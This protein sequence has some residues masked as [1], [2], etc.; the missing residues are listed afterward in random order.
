M[1]DILGLFNFNHGH[2]RLMASVSNLAAVEAE[3]EN[4]D[5]GEFDGE[6]VALFA[7]GE[8]AGGVVYGV[9]GGVGKGVGVK[10]GCCFGVTIVPKA[11]SIFCGCRHVS[12]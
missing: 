7:G 9:D 1:S 3:A 12:S 5:K 6:W 4:A 8:V 10:S 2:V 11:N